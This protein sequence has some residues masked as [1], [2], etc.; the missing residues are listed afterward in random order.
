MLSGNKKA[1][2]QTLVKPLATIRIKHLLKEMKNLPLSDFP[3]IIT[4]RLVIRQPTL[5][6]IQEIFLLRSNS[7]VNKYLNRK[8]DD[9]PEETLNFLKKV[10]ENFESKAGIYWSIMQKLDDKV[11]GTICLFDFSDQ[12]KKCEV[13]YELLPNYQRNGIMTEALRAVTKFVFETL[14][15]DTI[16]AFTHKKNRRSIDLLLKLNFKETDGIELNNAKIKMYH[17]YRHL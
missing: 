14:N 3:T 6:D 11:L 12:H 2:V 16:E 1:E 5:S 10:N 17:L 9:T 4:E 8:P 7:A 15:Y 13:G